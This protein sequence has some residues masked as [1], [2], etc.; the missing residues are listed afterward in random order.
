M[1]AIWVRTAFRLFPTDQSV[2]SASVRTIQTSSPNAC[3]GVQISANFSEESILR[4]RAR[5][6]RDIAEPFSIVDYPQLRRSFWGNHRAQLHIEREGR[7]PHAIGPV[8]ARVRMRSEKA[9]IRKSVIRAGVGSRFFRRAGPQN[10]SPYHFYF[11]SMF[12]ANLSRDIV[13][14]LVLNCCRLHI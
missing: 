13:T 1:D 6:T 9:H 5:L 12:R 8:P 7:W 2:R 11:L 10:A 4:I 14:V 3:S